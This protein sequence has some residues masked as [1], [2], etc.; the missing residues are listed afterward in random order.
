MGPV[1]IK[2][3]GRANIPETN[4]HGAF[5]PRGKPLMGR[6]NFAPGELP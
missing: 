5:A 4:A 3:G 1:V 2:R 6:L